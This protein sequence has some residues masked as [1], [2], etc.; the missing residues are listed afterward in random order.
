M[1][2][3]RFGNL[4]RLHH[5]QARKMFLAGETV[6]ICPSNLCPGKL[7]NPES[8]INLKE[9]REAS[10]TY[11]EMKPEEVWNNIRA[12]FRWYN[13]TSNETGKYISYWIEE[14]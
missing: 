1:E 2:A 11:E 13:C 3:I 7:W 5:T 9:I 8:Y 14:N 4:I 6:V 12:W 10:Y